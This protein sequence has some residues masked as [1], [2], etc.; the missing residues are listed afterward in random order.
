MSAFYRVSAILA[1]VFIAAAVVSF[2]FV[3]P[4]VDRFSYNSVNHDLLSAKRTIHEAFYH[5]DPQEWHALSIEISDEINM[6]IFI[7]KFSD[8]YIPEE[9]VNQFKEELGKS[10]IIEQETQQIYY[11]LNDEFILTAVPMGASQWVIYF[12][13][14]MTWI[15]AF[16][17][18]L[19]TAYFFLHRNRQDLKTLSQLLPPQDNDM[20]SKAFDVFSLSERIKKLVLQNAQKSDSLEKFII[21]QRDLLHGVAHEVRSPLARMEFAIEL[22]QTADEDEQADL[23]QQLDN[24]LKEI[25]ELVRELLRYS[26]LQHDESE[27][28]LT[29]VSLSELVERSL[30]KVVDV[31]PNISFKFSSKYDRVVTCDSQLLIIALANVLRNAGR[32]ARTQCVVTWRET[33]HELAIAIE[34]DGAGLPPGKI[35]HIFEPFTRLDSGRSRDSGGYGL[36]LAIVQAIIYRH[37]GRVVVCD[38][39]IG[40]AKFTLILPK[41]AID[42]SMNM[43][44]QKTDNK[45]PR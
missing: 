34:D 40:G 5:K 38:A 1:A 12:S 3:Y 31:Y 11:P 25:D 37:G 42:Y 27:L 17:V 4:M 24:Y 13:E 44:A 9:F 7:D 18:S 43:K 41:V 20:I 36:G 16:S 19:M 14:I 28:T 30:S 6:D 8:N 26:R 45:E 29:E 32:F 23:S 35:Q 21:S 33:E 15:M 22:L 10:G 2:T 39:D